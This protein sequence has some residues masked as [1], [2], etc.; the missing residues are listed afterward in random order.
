MVIGIDAHNAAEVERQLMPTP[1][2]VEPPGIGID[3]DCHA[4]PGAGPQDLC[5]V[6][7]AARSPQQLAPGHVAQDGGAGIGNRGEDALCLLLAA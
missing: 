2:E 3:F 5:N 4:M 6:N 7:L 1:V